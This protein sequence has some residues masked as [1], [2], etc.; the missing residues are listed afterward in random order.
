[1]P[2]TLLLDLDGVL[3]GPDASWVHAELLTIGFR[4]DVSRV[5]EAHYRGIERFD[6][7]EMTPA[8]D[9]FAY[10]YPNGFLDCL[11]VPEDLRRHA[12]ALL[13]HGS[14]VARNHLYPSSLAAVTTFAAKG[15]SIVVVTN[16]SVPGAR[17]SLAAEG[18]ADRTRGGPLTDV[19]ESAVLGVAKPD[20]RTIFEALRAAGE[21]NPASAVFVGDSRRI[22]GQA[23]ER[24]GVRFVHFDPPA[25]CHSP[26]HYHV[27]DLDDGG[28]RDMLRV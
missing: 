28:L 16:N 7:S 13:F 6:A 15:V 14:A 17:E 8:R 19:V 23:A 4:A 22:D 1:M 3:K 26:G 2:P 25:I 10:E 20:P 5:R 24:A 12:R 9:A 27:R 21:N 11:Q 18:L